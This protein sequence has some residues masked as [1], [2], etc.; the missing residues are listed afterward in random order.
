[1]HRSLLPF[2]S[3]IFATLRCCWGAAAGHYLADAVLRT[4][5]ARYG[6]AAD[7]RLLMGLMMAP[8]RVHRLIA[9][10]RAIRAFVASQA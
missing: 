5:P 4:A 6:L 1:M 9:A 10:G 2:V 8:L 3:F 7:T